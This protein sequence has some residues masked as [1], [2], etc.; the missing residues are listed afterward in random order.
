MCDDFNDNE[1]NVEMKTRTHVINEISHEDRLNM[2]SKT[3]EIIAIPR[4]ISVQ[5]TKIGIWYSFF[6]FTTEKTQF[7]IL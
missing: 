5:L 4:R 1:E 3:N 6:I 7:V 2:L